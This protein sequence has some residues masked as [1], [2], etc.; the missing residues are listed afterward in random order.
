LLLPAQALSGPCWADGGLGIVNSLNQ[1]SQ[2]IFQPQPVYA[3]PTPVGLSMHDQFCLG[4][5]KSNNIGTKQYLFFGG[6]FK[7]CMSLHM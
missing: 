6:Q 5:Y 2:V 1:L 3:Q 7:Y 4:K